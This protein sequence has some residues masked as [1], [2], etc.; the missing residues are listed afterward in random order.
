M[1]DFDHEERATRDQVGHN[2]SEMMM[3][4]VAT[5]EDRHARTVQDKT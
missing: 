3:R 4:D 5:V 1:Q 2:A